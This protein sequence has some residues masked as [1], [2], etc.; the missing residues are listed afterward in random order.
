MQS[1]FTN[2]NYVSLRLLRYVF[3]IDEFP[4]DYA[5][6]WEVK[7]MKYMMKKGLKKKIAAMVLAAFVAGVPGTAFAGETTSPTPAVEINQVT[8]PQEQVSIKEIKNSAGI[9]PNSLFY[10]L[11]RELEELRLLITKSEERLSALKA[12]YATERA[13]EAVMMVNEGEQ[14][15]AYDATDEYMKM[16]DSAAEH[17]NAAIKASDETEK[18][19]ASLN[20]AYKRSEEIL[21]TSLAETPEETRVTIESFFAAKAAFFAAKDQFMEA[22]RELKA[23]KKS[24]DP[25]AIRVAEEK[26]RAAE[27]LKDELEAAKD[28]VEPL[29]DELEAVKNAV[30]PA[31]K[32]VKQLTKQVEKR[33]ELGAKHIEKA[34]KKMEKVEEKAAGKA[35]RDEEKE[36]RHWEK[37]KKFQE[38]AGDRGKKAGEK[39]IDKASDGD[40]D[41]NDDDNDNDNDDDRD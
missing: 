26:V 39:A 34:N 15:L 20:E 35:K 12:Q 5:K 22:K 6:N 13:S 25:E 40:D 7:G 23:A 14:E 41:D 3:I 24:G 31:Q 36:K 38:K 9:L 21:K 33:I 18:A 4:R 2:I 29:E 17:I 37:M 11:E 19:L 30:L 32:E 1:D 28:A 8:A 10:S 27:A 16:L